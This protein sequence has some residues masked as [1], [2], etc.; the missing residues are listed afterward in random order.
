[1][2][3]IRYLTVLH[4]D[5]MGHTTTTLYVNHISL[6]KRKHRRLTS[7]R[8]HQINVG[9]HIIFVP[10]ILLTAFLFVRL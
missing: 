8:E 6:P 2:A 10:T 5:S 9:I 4:S 3:V 7:N 1:M